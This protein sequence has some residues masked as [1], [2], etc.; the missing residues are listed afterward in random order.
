MGRDALTGR[1]TYVQKTVQGTKR[2]AET[3]LARFVTE[4]GDGAHA[5][6]KSTTVGELLEQWFSHNEADW[7]P[8]VINSYR[9]IIDRQLV[10]RF[11]RTPLRRLTTADIDLFYAQLRKRG[12]ARGRPL[13]PA[14]V[15]RVHAVLRRAL[16]QGVKW[17]MLT[18][19]PAV[20]ASPPRE[21]RHEVSP[22]DPA[23]V[24]RLIAHAEETNPALGCFLRLAATS[25]AR[26]GELC[27][28]RWRHIN[29]D[30]GGLLIERSIVEAG[31]G[32]LVEKDTKTHAARRLRLDAGTVARLRQHR[33]EREGY[34]T[35]LRRMVSADDFVFSLDPAGRTPWRPGYVTLAFCRLRADLDLPGVRLHDL[36]HFAATALLSGGKDVRTVSGRLGHA[37][38]AT[39]LGVYAHFVAAADGDAADHLGTLLDKA[40][41]AKM[42]HP[43]VTV[44]GMKD[45]I[46]FDGDDTLWRAEH[47]YDEA[48]ARA[49]LIVGGAGLDPTA[50][51]TLQ[52][53]IDVANVTRMGL[54][55][56]RFPTSSVEAYEQ[57]AERSG[58]SVDDNVRDHV[59]RAA[60]VVFERKA[61]LVPGVRRVLQQLRR[62]HRLALLTQGDAT[63][64]E[65]RIDDS[66]LRSSFDLV[67]IVDRKNE[68]TFS[69]VLHKL[70]AQ[71]E[72]SWSVGNSIPSDINP[73]LRLGMSAIWIE[74]HV[75]AHER[76]EDSPA[77]GRFLT[78]RELT[79]V[80]A[81]IREHALIA[82]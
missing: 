55:R 32:D 81:I 10:P 1:K 40:V 23:D 3:E 68:A 44:I 37:N 11:G 46:V 79:D 61:P 53:E 70:G 75:W 43:P 47:L 59:R 9:R 6:T 7:S 77:Q 48:R 57:L 74:A 29:L 27:A 35:Q 24:A 25:G 18:I 38:A 21:P 26:R 30:D 66:G 41:P 15:K 5:S 33:G 63:V 82:S 2:E 54:S 62:D 8:T 56:H 80:P 72:G 36:R 14:T 69:T 78:A 50:W 60:E 64:Q 52:R 22:P 65:K 16:A 76:R 4:V 67:E 39:T 19:N 71:P 28:L 20:N 49:A 42:S 51:D 31:N 34:G 58:V 73:A 13:S 17:G 45:L 12:G